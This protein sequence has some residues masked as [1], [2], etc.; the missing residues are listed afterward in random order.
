MARLTK[1]H[2]E[3]NGKTVHSIIYASG[4]IKCIGIQFT[5]GDRLDIHV[6]QRF[7]KGHT[8]LCPAAENPYFKTSHKIVIK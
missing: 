6:D 1:I 5:D 3:L 2:K 4:P 8:Q 7:S